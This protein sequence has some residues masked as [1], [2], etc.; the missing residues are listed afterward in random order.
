MGLKFRP[1]KP[2]SFK[3]WYPLRR[4]DHDGHGRFWTDWLQWEDVTKHGQ[5][6]LVSRRRYCL[7]DQCLIEERNTINCCDDATNTCSS[8]PVP[9]CSQLRE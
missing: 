3:D 1:K 6:L 8:D 9:L 4:C 5:M 2:A 7:K